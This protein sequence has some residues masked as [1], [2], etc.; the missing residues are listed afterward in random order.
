MIFTAGSDEQEKSLR[1][2]LDFIQNLRISPPSTNPQDQF[3]ALHPIRAW[4]IWLP[5]SFL[6]LTDRSLQVLV[7]LAHFYAVTL[8]VQLYLPAPGLAWYPRMRM[9]AIEEI[10]REIDHLKAAADMEGIDSAIGLMRCPREIAT[11][12]RGRLQMAE[13]AHLPTKI[14]RLDE[15]IS[16]ADSLALAATID[17]EGATYLDA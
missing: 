3:K 7:T 4:V 17:L 6:H 9:V 11:H 15:D 13:D 16:M 8:A 10:A 12:F 14:H 2:L 1:L 5:V